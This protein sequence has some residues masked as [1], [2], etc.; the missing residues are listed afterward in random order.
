L[1]AVKN[2]PKAITAQSKTSSIAASAEAYC[3]SIDYHLC[4][5][6]F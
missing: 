5:Y 4:N 6:L 2:P 1:P 3:L